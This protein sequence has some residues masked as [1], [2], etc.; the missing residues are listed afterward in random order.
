MPHRI[1]PC[2]IEYFHAPLDIGH[3]PSDISMPHGILDHA[4]WD[5]GHGI[6]AISGGKK[7]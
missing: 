1:F 7:G 6:L 3:A 4:S 5:I 2:P